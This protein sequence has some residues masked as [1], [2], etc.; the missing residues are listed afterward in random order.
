MTDYKEVIPRSFWSGN[1]KPKAS[2]VAQLI[3]QLQKLPDNLEI[4]IGFGD[5]CQLIVYNINTD[6]MHLEI[7][8][9]DCDDDE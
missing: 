6:S 1:K 8:K 7:A 4:K 2:T 5:G 9:V 3:K